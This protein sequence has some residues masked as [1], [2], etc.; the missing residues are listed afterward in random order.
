MGEMMMRLRVMVVMGGEF[1]EEGLM[2]VAV[3]GG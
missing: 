3:I 1:E 2:A